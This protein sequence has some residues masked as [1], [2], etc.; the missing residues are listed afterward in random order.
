[1]DLSN[2]T[3]SWTLLSRDYLPEYQDQCYLQTVLAGMWCSRMVLI[4][5]LHLFIDMSDFDSTQCLTITP[6]TADA[7]YLRVSI[8]Y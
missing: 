5:K 8:F 4:G 7:A 3:L 6:L 2:N 1:M